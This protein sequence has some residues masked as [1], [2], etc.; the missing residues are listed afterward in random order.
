MGCAIVRQ[1]LPVPGGLIRQTG[2]FFVHQDPL[3]PLPSF[4]VIASS[5]HIRSI[6]EMAEAEYAE[7]AG[8]VRER[9]RL[10]SKRPRKLN[11]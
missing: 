4:L 8:L 10:R 1:A 7:F 6:V 2:H 9:H 5:Q 3:I 11:I